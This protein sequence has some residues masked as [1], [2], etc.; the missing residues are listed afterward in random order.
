MNR[1]EINQELGELFKDPKRYDSIEVSF[2]L[3]DKEAFSYRTVHV[4]LSNAD[5]PL[6][7]NQEEI[8]RQIFMTGLMFIEK[9]SRV[10][11]EK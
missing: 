8:D 2:T 9:N 10:K 4:M 5:L 11:V 3:S 6:K 1:E 7:Y